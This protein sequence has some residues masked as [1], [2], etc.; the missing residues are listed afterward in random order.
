MT[1]R[2]AHLGRGQGEA[3]GVPVPERGQLLRGA[4]RARLG[5]GVAAEGPDG[6]SYL[7]FFGGILTVSLGQAHERVNRRAP[8]ADRPPRPRLDPLPDPAHRRA[9]REARLA[10]ARAAQEGVLHG[11][12]HRG[13]R[14]RRRARAD[15]HRAARR[16]SRS[17]T[18]TRGARCS[19]MSLTAH[20]KYRVVP[21]ADRRRSSTRTPPY[22]YRC[23]FKPQVPE[24]RR[25]VRAGH[26]GPDP[27]DDHGA[28]RRLPRR[29]DPGGRRLHHGAR[30]LLQD[31]GRHRQ[32]VRRP[33]HLATRCRRA[34]AAP[35]TRCGASSTTTASSPDIMTMAK[36]IANGLPIG[37]DHRDR[38][39]SPT[40]GR[41][42][43]SPPSAATR[44]ARPRP[45]PRST[46]SSTR[47]LPRTPRAM[48][49]LLRDGLEALQKKFPRSSATSAAR[50]SCRRIEL[51]K[52]ETANDRTPAPETAAAR[53]F[54]ETK[55]RGA[56]HRQGGALRQ[57]HP[58]R[59]G[60]QLGKADIAEGLRIL[61]ESFT[62][63]RG[64]E[65]AHDLGLVPGLSRPSSRTTSR[66]TSTPR[67]APRPSAASTASTRRASRRAPRRS[68][69]R[70]SSR[71]SRPATCAARR[72]T[73]LEQNILGYSCARVCPVEVLC[74]GDCVYQQ[75]HG[76]PIA[77][78]PPPA[79]RDRGDDAAR[80]AGAS[81][82]RRS[83]RRARLARW[84]SSAEARRRSP[85]RPTSRSRGTRR[86]SSRS[87]PSS[88]GSTRPGSRRTRSTRRTPCARPS[89]CASSAS[90]CGRG[91]RSA[92]TCEVAIARSTEYDAVFLGARAR[93][94]REARHA[95]RGGAG[96][97]RRDGVDRA[98][99]ARRRS[100]EARR[101]AASSSSEAGTPPSTW[102]ASA[103]SSGAETSRWSTAAT[104]RR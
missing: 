66:S 6:K 84:P 19:R 95:G 30:R 14:D 2:R 36:G 82:R 23:P 9:R 42:G 67:R 68:T 50:G 85:A 83:S 13:R 98:H 58:H 90:S 100:G 52:D 44:S 27:D 97:A 77:D 91:S 86:R 81:S 78:R 101:S 55:K 56:P 34:S 60:A 37:A 33:L 51:V 87:A 8:R 93:H 20:S 10:G 35:A 57:R 18:A 89:G 15:P 99:E 53:L 12:R 65:I 71:R 1:R 61:D 11:E 5:Q 88:E 41:G 48:G 54:E 16:S 64:D 3:Q 76:A 45:T 38:R 69:S 25:E 79:L 73:I 103:R 80:E 62:A 29:A 72:E 24:L 39:R 59:P 17:A 49:K 74:V 22:C 31:R 70:R 21:D 96:R 75:W 7:D 4:G 43:T 104:P 63:M 40:R 46:R 47:S 28:H 92:W 32:E 26:R 94:G 102:R